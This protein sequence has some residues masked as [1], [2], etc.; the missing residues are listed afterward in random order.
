[1]PKNS[2]ILFLEKYKLVPNEYYEGHIT[3]KNLFNVVKKTDI[4]KNKLIN[5]ITQ[6]EIKKK[7][8]EEA[9]QNCKKLD[10]IL[11]KFIKKRKNHDVRRKWLN[12]ELLQSCKDFNDD[13]Y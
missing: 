5:E 11:D 4:E 10:D 7:Y 8:N 13:N 1:M 9:K 12:S 2:I 3:D 6:F